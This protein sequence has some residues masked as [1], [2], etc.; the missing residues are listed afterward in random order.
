MKGVLVRCEMLVVLTVLY[1]FGAAFVNNSES[2]L[3]EK[4]PSCLLFK[5]NS[6]LSSKVTVMYFYICF[7]LCLFCKELLFCCGQSLDFA[8]CTFGALL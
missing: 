5:E 4:H 3:P 7:V 8:V 2:R 1:L 6:V